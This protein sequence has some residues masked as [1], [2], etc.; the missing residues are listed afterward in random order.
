MFPR[1]PPGC[2]NSGLR[3]HNAAPDL[4]R[5]P[6]NPARN[7]GHCSEIQRW[8]STKQSGYFR[9]LLRVVETRHCV[10]ITRRWVWGGLLE[11]RP[12]IWATVVKSSTEFLQSSYQNRPPCVQ[13]QRCFASTRESRHL[14]KREASFHAHNLLTIP[15]IY[16][17]PSATPLSTRHSP[18]A[19][20]HTILTGSKA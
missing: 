10:F 7:S 12:V 15:L 17:L 14:A 18:H 2:G 5:L 9:V 13:E 20:R 16:R 1:S 6:E 3:I 11:T 8:V 4:G 19:T